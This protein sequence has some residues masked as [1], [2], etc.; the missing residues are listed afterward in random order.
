M[1]N[2][3]KTKMV[4]RE[5]LLWVAMSMVGVVLMGPTAANLARGLIGGDPNRGNVDEHGEP[6]YENR[7]SDEMSG[8]NNP[9]VV[10]SVGDRMLVQDSRSAA[11][12]AA[13]DSPREAANANSLAQVPQSADSPEDVVATVRRE[14]AEL[15]AEQERAKMAAANAA[16]SSS[17]N[18]GPS[19][20]VDQMIERVDREMG[21]DSVQSD[22]ATNEVPAAD[23]ESG[24][25]ADSTGDEIA[26]DIPGDEPARADMGAMDQVKKSPAAD[27][28]SPDELVTQRSKSPK[29]SGQASD[30]DR[31]DVAM[32]DQQADRPSSEERSTES[33]ESTKKSAWSDPLEFE[34][35]LEIDDMPI[36]DPGNRFVESQPTDAGDNMNE[37]P[38]EVPPA[39]GDAW[40]EATVGQ[41]FWPERHAQLAGLDGV[42]FV[43]LQNSAQVQ[44]LNDQ[45]QVQQ[46]FVTEREADFDWTA[47]IDASWSQINEPVRNELQTGSRTGR[48][49]EDEF[50]A[51]AGVRK[52]LDQ[53]GELAIAS[54]IGTVDNNSAFLAPPDQGLASFSLDYRQPLMRGRG[55]DIAQSQ[56][57]L[58]RLS[59]EV[60][61]HATKQHLQQFLVDVVTAYWNLYRARGILSQ[62]YRNATRARDVV[63]R[64]MDD[65]NADSLERQINRARSIASARQS[66]VIDAEYAVADAQER[67]MNLT[68]G[69][70]LADANLV[71]IIP[72][73][74]PPRFA[75]P[76]D[77]ASVTELAISNR[78]EVKEVLAEIKAVTVEQ[79][80][81]VDSLKPQL[82][83]I[84]SSYVVGVN[85]NKDVG[86]ALGNQ[87]SNG[88]PSYSVGMAFEVPI[89]RRA[90][91]A[92]VYR[93]EIQKR[94][95]QNRLRKTLGDVTLAAR[96]AFRDVY[97]LSAIVDNNQEVV[98][99]TAADLDVLNQQM[100]LLLAKDQT[101][102]LYLNDLLLS[103][104][105]LSAAEQ[106]LLDSQAKLAIAYVV[107]KRATGELLQNDQHRC[108]ECNGTIQ[109]VVYEEVVQPD[110][111]ETMALEQGTIMD[112]QQP[113]SG[114]AERLFMEENQSKPRNSSPRKEMEPSIPLQ[115]T[116][117]PAGVQPVPPSSETAGGVKAF[118]PH[119]A[120]RFRQPSS[121][122]KRIR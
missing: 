53:G 92:R 59:T 23:A 51:G 114:D 111:G 20:D 109:Q 62:R 57:V 61:E 76:H 19:S 84:L 113:V 93:K 78:P 112:S 119:A 29:P 122:A 105:R 8:V 116:N 73:D 37:Q 12:L 58:A 121:A 30:S 68:H 70:S 72:T 16:D 120:R 90:S 43:A 95:L 101:A 66:E 45:P 94:L 13:S 89:G 34:S 47:F 49:E 88:D 31:G 55:R 9:S 38:M 35:G 11:G 86:A 3:E 4:L 5:P 60:T 104:D 77:L 48:F 14:L 82:D 80:L 27:S 102:A 110:Q 39:G 6:L 108:Q 2:D 33:A 56:I 46:T 99:Q 91:N 42:V 103:Q 15:R 44:I 97:R 81:A 107:L 18:A 69:D 106:S 79:A 71:E 96:S 115:R 87:F 100:K 17:A 21:R 75:M 85:P 41:Q 7:S 83:A 40:W 67:L 52:R 65:A 117:P 54:T 25:A 1:T 26:V 50:F 22:S 32:N 63:E 98:S 118:V 28:S 64:L 74:A 10:S 36:A 24:G